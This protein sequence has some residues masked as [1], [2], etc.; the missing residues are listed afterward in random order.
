MASFRSARV[1]H[2]EDPDDDEDGTLDP[3]DELEVSF[4]PML[5]RVYELMLP[6]LDA[7][8]NFINAGQKYAAFLKYVHGECSSCNHAQILNE[9][10]KLLTAIVN[11][12]MDINGILEGKEESAGK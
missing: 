9:K 6:S 10:T 12:L 8:L 2:G 3:E 5:P 1:V 11:K 7:R 4:E